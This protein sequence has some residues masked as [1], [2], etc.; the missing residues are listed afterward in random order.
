[1]TGSL[2]RVGRSLKHF[3]CVMLFVV[4]V[5]FCCCEAKRCVIM[6]N[7]KSFH[8][9]CYAAILVSSKQYFLY[10]IENTTYDVG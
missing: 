5:F 3:V 6:I 1:M 4:I 7:I 9:R 8:K 10:M 2:V